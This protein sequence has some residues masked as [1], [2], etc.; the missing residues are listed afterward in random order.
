MM[1]NMTLMTK[2]LLVAVPV[3]ALLLTGCSGD[4]SDD[5]AG[6]AILSIVAS[7]NVYGDIAAQVAGD[8]AEVTSII[9]GASQ[10]PHEYEASA[11]DR[12]ALDDADVV[13][14]N[15]GGY[16]PFVDALLEAGDDHDRVVIDVV[17]VSGLAPDD[18][19]EDGHDDHGHEE[20]EHADEDEGHDDHDHEGHD[21]IEGFNEHV[22]YDLGTVEKLAHELAH[23]LGELD[24]GNADAY[25]ANADAF[26]SEIEK[27]ET[28]AADLRSA[29]EGGHVAITEPVPLYLLQAVGLENV[30]P[31]DFSE[32]VEEGADVPPRVLQATLDLFADGTDVLLLAY[33]AQTEDDTT[34]KVKNAAEAADVPVID[35]TE[36]LPDGLSYLEWQ[37]A[38]LD[39]LAEAL[40]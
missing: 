33:N 15:G 2:R 25:E 24:P 10:D 7:T 37:K 39:A 35:F 11:Q 38:N 21:H 19:D 34:V 5:P 9:T 31:D 23:E 13:I 22:W 14:K 28:R 40:P 4:S 16:D 18:H 12:L 1:V 17:E 27:L 26:V 29:H 36:T 30:T 20:D 6:D 8:H 32:A 3:A